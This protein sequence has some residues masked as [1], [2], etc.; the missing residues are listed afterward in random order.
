MTAKPPFN[1]D[2]DKVVVMHTNDIAWEK[3]EHPGVW[4]K[5]LE[6]VNDPRKGRETCLL[7]LEP[8]TTLPTEELTTRVEIFT[9]E[10]GYSDERGTYGAHTFVRNPAGTRLTLS[11]TDGCV[12]YVKRRVPI[13]R[14]TERMVIDANATEWTPFP[15]RGAKVLHLYRDVHG[16]ETSRF[17]QVYPD[18][19][20]PS[21]DHAMGE[22][23][24]VVGGCLKDEYDA[25]GPGTWFRFPIGVPHAPYTEAD[26]CLM[27]IREGDL[28]W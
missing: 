6:R 2:P 23:T 11:S 12:L 27:L 26:G 13:R 10:G 15:H 3:T 25:Y 1:A 16:I 28:V 19:K 8:N 14:D 22:E 9:L 20:I 24:L 21:H 18:K 5:L 7:R 4:Q 17:G